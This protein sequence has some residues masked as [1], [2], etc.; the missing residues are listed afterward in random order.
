MMGHISS[1][2]RMSW[3]RNWVALF[4]VAFVSSLATL[5]AMA[6]GPPGQEEV[7]RDFQKTVTLGSGQSLRVENKFGEVRVHGEAGRDVR[8]SATIR[9]QGGSHDEADS[10]AQKI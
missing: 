6:A 5:P 4:R 3:R 8:I 2:R 7:S 1:T 9:V 10:Y